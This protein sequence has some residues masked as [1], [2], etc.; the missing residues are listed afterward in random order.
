MSE[1]KYFTYQEIKELLKM[2]MPWRTRALITFQYASGCRIGELL[3]YVNR[4]RV[5]LKDEDK[6]VI[7]NKKGE[8]KYKEWIDV[9]QGLLKSNIKINEEEGIIEWSMPNFKVK[10]EAKK[11][12]FPFVLKQEFILWDVIHIWVN[13]S[14]KYR[15]EPCNEQVFNIR[16]TR[17]RQLTREQIQAYVKKT[18]KTHLN[19]HASHAFRRSRGTHLAEIFGYDA[20]EIMESLGHSSLQSGVHYVATA[21]RKKKMKAKL[22]QM[23]KDRRENE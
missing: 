10:N 1:I 19:K 8:I 20:Y 14:K 3:P 13:G 23:E 22:E 9:S 6:K 7:K 18:G 2:K 15:V 11:T 21:Q 16:Q 12:K 4:H 5:A 17:A